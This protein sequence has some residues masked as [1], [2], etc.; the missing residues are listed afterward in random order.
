M[1]WRPVLQGVEQEP[2]PLLRLLGRDS[3]TINSGGEKI[4]AEEIEHA[5]MRLELLKLASPRFLQCSFDPRAGHGP[6][7]L[8]G[9]R[10]LCEQTGAEGFLEIV[11]E[12]VNDY[13]AELGRLARMIE[14]SAWSL[15]AIAVCPVGDLKS[16][17][18]GGPRPPA[19]A[20]PAAR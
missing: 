18:P 3:V 12:S 14:Q 16:V 5:V 13:A 11:V 2:K 19:P 9:Y 10:G 20:S 7:E 15:A 1:R 4:F 6:K 17:L 8:A